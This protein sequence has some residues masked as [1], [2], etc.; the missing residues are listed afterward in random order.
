VILLNHVIQVL[1]GPDERLSGQD[2]LGLQFGDGLMGRLT[3]VERDLP[4]KSSG[5]SEGSW[6]MPRIIHN[7]Q[8][9]TRTQHSLVYAVAFRNT[10]RAPS[11]MAYKIKVTTH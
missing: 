5:F 6:V 2:A 11:Y 3:A 7:Q 4:L 8:I 10:G 9:C 1:V